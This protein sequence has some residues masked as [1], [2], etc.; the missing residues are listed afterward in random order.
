M[1]MPP[2]MHQ[3]EGKRKNHKKKG[4]EGY[5]NK[6]FSHSQNSI[7]LHCHAAQLILTHTATGFLWIF[8]GAEMLQSWGEGK[9][10]HSLLSQTKTT[11]QG[12]APGLNTSL[13]SV[14]FTQHT[15]GVCILKFSNYFLLIS[16]IR[17]RF[18]QVHTKTPKVPGNAEVL[19]QWHHQHCPGSS[20]S[21]TFSANSDYRGSWHTI[22]AALERF[23][24]TLSTHLHE[25]FYFL[26]FCLIFSAF[27]AC[28]SAP[29]F[30]L[31]W[32]M[33]EKD[34]RH[35]GFWLSD[36]PDTWSIFPNTFSSRPCIHH[37]IRQGFWHPLWCSV[38]VL[39]GKWQG[40]STSALGA[41]HPAH[42]CPMEVKIPKISILP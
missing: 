8:K 27:P 13:S 12:L 4:T 31:G 26:S 32:Q 15:N 20:A 18:N 29:I 17:C 39:Q 37:H 25:C 3:L 24:A 2:S 22:K 21:D 9:K 6:A 36:Y 38:H 14:Q 7:S 40:H 19:V 23:C 35:Q 30:Q 33:W 42:L 10:I 11:Y 16:K 1:R 5:S 28:F 34:V 41:Q